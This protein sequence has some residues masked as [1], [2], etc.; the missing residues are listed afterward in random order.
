MSK[1]DLSN[2]TAE[3]I[4]T[5]CS[6]SMVNHFF[7]CSQDEQERVENFGLVLDKAKVFLKERI[8]MLKEQKSFQE[9]WKNYS[10]YILLL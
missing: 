9:N 6:E 3:N 8:P 5:L 4:H 2:I 10:Q 7:M 1:L